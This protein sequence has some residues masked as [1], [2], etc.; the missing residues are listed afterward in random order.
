VQLTRPQLTLIPDEISEAVPVCDSVDVPLTLQN[1]GGITLDWQAVEQADNPGGGWRYSDSNAPGGA[2]YDWIDISGVGTEVGFSGDDESVNNLPIGFAFLFYGNAYTTFNLSANGY[3]SFTSTEEGQASWSNRAL[4]NDTRPENMIAPWWD[5]QS[6][7]DAGAVY[8]YSGG[9]SLIIS[10]IDV[11]SYSGGGEYT[12]Q[13]IL[14]SSGKIVFQYQDMGTNRLDEATIGVQNADQTE[15][16]TINY[17]ELYVE[18][19]MAISLCPGDAVEII[20]AS[21]SLAPTNSQQV[22]ARLHSC[23]LPTDLFETVVEFSSTDPE[24]DWL[25]EMP[26]TLDVGGL[27]N[28]VAVNDLT[29]TPEGAGVRL[30][31]SPTAGAAEYEIWSGVTPDVVPATGSYVGTTSETTWPISSLSSEIEFYIVVA[32]H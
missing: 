31:W 21:G 27:V 10:Y 12:Y 30:N 20:P 2:A 6:P 29:I 32:L 7:Q 13:M 22:I 25:V 4:P 5:D 15:G 19:L 26:V 14:L 23:C 3:L 28:P 24:V 16:L 9:D 8:R 11:P 17:N 1:D 18:D